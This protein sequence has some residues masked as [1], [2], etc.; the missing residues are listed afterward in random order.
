LVREAAAVALGK[1]GAAAEPAV[2]DLSRLTGD[3][4]E[5]VRLAASG[6]LAKI[7]AAEEAVKKQ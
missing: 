4:V 5:P 7:G 3:Q 1:F 2:A 6:A